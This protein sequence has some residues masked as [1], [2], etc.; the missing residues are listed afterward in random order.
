VP[1]ANAIGVPN[2][3]FQQQMMQFQDERMVVVV[4][5]PVTARRLWE[6]TLAHCQ[7]RQLFGKPLAKMQIT[8]HKLVHLMIQITAAQE[9]SYPCIRK[10]VR[11]EDATLDISMAKV[12][13]TTMSQLVA[14]S[15]MQLFG[16]AG[17]CWENPTARA[18]VDSRLGRDRGR[19]RRGDEADRGEEPEGPSRRIRPTILDPTRERPD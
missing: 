11:G 1:V 2:R 19:R 16:G 4:T 13:A 12:F 18:F 7:E 17:Y 3:G 10:M 5:S 15:C 8:Q 9:L 6:L 14:T